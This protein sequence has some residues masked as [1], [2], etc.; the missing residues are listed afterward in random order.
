MCDW[1]RLGPVG[2]DISCVSSPVQRAGSTV[3][4]AKHGGFVGWT[5][6]GGRPSSAGAQNYAAICLDLFA[7]LLINRA[8]ARKFSDHWSSIGETSAKAYT[9]I[10]RFFLF[11]SGHVTLGLT[12]GLFQINASPTQVRGRF[13]RIASNSCCL[14]ADVS[15]SLSLRLS[16]S[17]TLCLAQ[18][19]LPEYIRVPLAEIVDSR[20]IMRNLPQSVRIEA[21]SVQKRLFRKAY[22]LSSNCFW[23]M[24]CVMPPSGKFRNTFAC[25]LIC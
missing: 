6:F 23:K 10:N 24:S 4:L 16:T 22:L 15:S 7:S 3:I 20:N 17:G 21:G 13:D 5:N 11:R 8:T 2:W 14:S 9:I 25:F 1:E 12:F 19:S 18:V